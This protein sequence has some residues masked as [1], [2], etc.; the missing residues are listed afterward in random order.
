MVKHERNYVGMRKSRKAFTLAEVLIT[1][2]IIGVVAAMTLPTLITNYQKRAT[3]A[4]LKRAY[5]VIKQA[6]LM[7]YDQVGDPAA[8]EALAMGND[9]Y[10][11][12]YWAP[13]IKGTVC[14]TSKECGYS[15]N[16]PWAFANG[17]KMTLGVVVLDRRTTFYTSDGFLYVVFV[18]VGSLDNTENVANSS[19]I[20]DINGGKGPNKLGKDVFYFR[21]ISD[22]KGNDMQ[23]LGYNYSDKSVNSDCSENGNG[24]YCAEK[25]RRDGWKIL[26]D[27]PW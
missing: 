15:S 4:K 18:A 24:Y 16:N 13:Y 26:K 1:L 23:P 9:N 6:Y 22:E 12:T 10:F 11:R 17:Q 7:S 2:G 20:V 5:S 25:I 14:K 27:Y 8:D 21:R 19:I 3:V